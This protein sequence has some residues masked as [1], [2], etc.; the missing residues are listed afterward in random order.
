M[1]EIRKKDKIYHIETD[2][3]SGYWHFSFDRYHD[4]RNVHF[5]TLRVF[6]VDTLV[7]GGV[8]PMHPHKDIEVITY[9][10]DGEFEHADN[11][12]NGGVL[13]PGDVQHTTVGSGMQHAEIN[14][15]NERP[16]TFIQLWII[17]KAPGLSPSLEQ[18]HVHPEE[19]LNR[20]LLLVSSNNSDALPIQQDAEVYAATIEPD[21]ILTHQLQPGY[22]AYLYLISGEMELN[23]SRLSSGD[24]AKIQDQTAIS[25]RGVE[26]S[27][28]FMVVVRVD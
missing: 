17:P 28:V 25:L 2:W 19:R 3:F 15:S 20:I 11:L 1:I 22:G 4:P 13:F 12:G 5:G 8:W 26:T 14:H 6:N 21:V 10:A 9:C 16:M 23:G 24:A 18:R 7:P 27:E